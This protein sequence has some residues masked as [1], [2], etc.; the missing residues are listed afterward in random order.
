M[1]IYSVKKYIY[2]ERF[3]NDIDI[4]KTCMILLKKYN[5][6]LNS[7]PTNEIFD[8]I[9]M[10]ID[11]I[12]GLYKVT[13]KMYYPEFYESIKDKISNINEEWLDNYENIHEDSNVYTVNDTYIQEDEDFYEDKFMYETEEL[14]F[15]DIS[16]DKL[17]ETV[18]KTINI[19]NEEKY[20]NKINRLIRNHEDYLFSEE[21]YFEDYVYSIYFEEYQNILF[22]PVLGSD[23]QLLKIAAILNKTIPEDIIALNN[24]NK[25]DN[26]Y[27]KNG[28]IC[29]D[30]KSLGGYY[31]TKSLY[32]FYVNMDS[33]YSKYYSLNNFFETNFKNI[34][35]NAN[36]RSH[37]ININHP[38]AT[39]HLIMFASNTK[40][41]DSGNYVE[42]LKE[43]IF[44]PDELDE[45]YADCRNQKINF[46]D[47][48]KYMEMYPKYRKKIH[49][50]SDYGNNI[51]FEDIV[52]CE[53]DLNI[54][55]KYELEN[56]FL[57]YKEN[58]Q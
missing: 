23:K 26:L 58:S 46:R 49:F 22:Y 20:R 18:L 42:F 29:I 39:K 4:I 41:Y 35:I 33:M 28:E 34:Y 27:L 10:N 15:T 3:Y 19:I 32:E 45:Y 38:N 48:F 43:F 16:D 52:F 44:V 37:N 50:M 21:L 47:Y 6:D 9:T 14:Y 57:N 5:T 2:T 54:L 8:K 30:P 17:E 31:V 53:E 51:I 40:N 7:I 36:I 55:K 13:L 11:K 24:W 56:I 12:V 25:N 1:N